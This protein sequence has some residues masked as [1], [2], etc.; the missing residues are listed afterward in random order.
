M[1]A[2]SCTAPRAMTTRPSP[3]R[4]PSLSR[5]F[6][7]RRS[8]VES[9][10]NAFSDEYALDSPVTID[11]APLGPVPPPRQ[12][13]F[14]N[15]F[16]DRN[17]SNPSLPLNNLQPPLERGSI[18]KRRLMIDD[19]PS[20]SAGGLGRSLSSSSRTTIPRSQSPY[21]GPTAP[22]HPYSMY[23]QMTRASSV[24]SQSTLRPGSETP[25]VPR[26]GPEHPYELYPQNT[27]PEEDEDI[28]ARGIPLGF[29]RSANFQSSSGGS[30]S[31]VGD[32]IGSDGHVEQLPPYTRY[33]DNTV[34]KGN[35]DDINRRRFSRMSQT[36]TQPSE[37]TS[38][39]NLPSTAASTT[40]LAPREEFEQET[41]AQIAR[42]EGWRESWKEKMQKR[43]I[44]GLP[45]WGLITIILIVIFSATVGGVVGGVIGNR[46]GAER[47]Y[48]NG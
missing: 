8:S 26:G 10:D 39:P 14:D 21:T 7:S 18:A 12:G 16:H 32:I 6:R 47:A 15:P 40:L 31:D 34:A 13:Y 2:G 48:A 42:K 25:F 3:S 22:S 35:M 46:Q 23:P 44:A 43:T 36:T 28:T 27:V 38:N 24:A 9:L 33:A 41:E 5:S 30:S 11:N 17:A 37:T 20:S 29:P 45:L 1:Q 19:V 4:E